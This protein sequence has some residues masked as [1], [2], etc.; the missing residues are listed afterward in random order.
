MRQN[1][2]LV[3]EV[4]VMYGLNTHA[5]LIIYRSISVFLGVNYLEVMYDLGVWAIMFGV[6]EVD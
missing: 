5:G 1:A 4:S 3:W 6:S 2:W